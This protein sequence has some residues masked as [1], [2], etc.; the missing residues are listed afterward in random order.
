[1]RATSHNRADRSIA[2][3][4]YKIY[5]SLDTVKRRMGLL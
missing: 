2:W 4:I 1:M 5:N 3:S